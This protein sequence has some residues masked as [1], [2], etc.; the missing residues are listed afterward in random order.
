M[1][2]A[3][4]FSSGAGHPGWAGRPVGLG[5]RPFLRHHLPDLSRFFSKGGRQA[6]YS[7]LHC[8]RRDGVLAGRRVGHFRPFSKDAMAG[9]CHRRIRLRR[10]M[11]A[12]VRCAF[13]LHGSAVRRCHE[14]NRFGQVVGPGDRAGPGRWRVRGAGCRPSLGELSG[15][16]GGRRHVGMAPGGR[17]FGSSPGS[18]S[19]RRF[20]VFRIFRARSGPGRSGLGNGRHCQVSWRGAP[21]R[22]RVG[23][24]GAQQLPLRHRCA[25]ELC[26]HHP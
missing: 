5:C 15:P 21:I 24:A 26:Q 18:W 12:L 23:P 10:C 20:R 6:L 2:R 13:L 7:A 25:V 1:A 8:G 22:R 14:E 4:C 17:R 11:N 3:F 19:D 9:D 16:A